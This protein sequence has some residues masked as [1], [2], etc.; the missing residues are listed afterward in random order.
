MESIKTFISQIHMFSSA[1]QSSSHI[2]VNSH[3]ELSRI[4]TENKKSC[5][6]TSKNENQPQLGLFELWKYIINQQPPSI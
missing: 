5:F 3:T 2:K 4:Y 1:V 6:K